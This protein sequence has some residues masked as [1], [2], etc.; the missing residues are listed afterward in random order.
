M[1]SS[2]T[3]WVCIRGAH[4]TNPSHTT[5][6]VNASSTLI[7]SMPKSKHPVSAIYPYEKNLSVSIWG[8]CCKKCWL[9]GGTCCSSELSGVT[10]LLKSMSLEKKKTNPKHREMPQRIIKHNSKVNASK[11]RYIHIF[12]IS[13]LYVSEF[14][15]ILFSLSPLQKGWLEPQHA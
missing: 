9:F 12:D 2:L 3:L 1:I 7:E 13:R 4:H 8:N 15:H 10:A 6:T 14:Q 5:I 11:K